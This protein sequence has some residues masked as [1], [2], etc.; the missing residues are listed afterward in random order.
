MALLLFILIWLVRFAHAWTMSFTRV[1]ESCSVFVEEAL[2]WMWGSV[3]LFRSDPLRTLE[4]LSTI[5]R[6][7]GTGKEEMTQ[8]HWKLYYYHT[9]SHECAHFFSIR[10]IN[11]RA[12]VSSFSETGS[13]FTVLCSHLLFFIHFPTFSPMQL[14]LLLI[15][16]SAAP[17]SAPYVSQSRLF[18][19]SSGSSA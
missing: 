5:Y 4:P 18:W 1:C 14:H 19:D 12:H 6:G 8:S 2:S 17:Q 13:T 11:I 15:S 16:L 3:G 10:H 7:W 9:F